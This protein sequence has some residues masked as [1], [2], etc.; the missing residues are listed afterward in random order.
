MVEDGPVLFVGPPY[1]DGVHGPDLCDVRSGSGDGRRPF[2]RARSGGA[3]HYDKTQ[4]DSNR[5]LPVLSLS[6]WRIACRWSNVV[7]RVGW[8]WRFVEC[9]S[10]DPG[11][12]VAVI[13]TCSVVPSER[14]NPGEGHVC[15]SYLILA[16]GRLHIEYAWMTIDSDEL[17]VYIH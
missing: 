6:L 2:S 3:T 14:T 5:D 15:R 10:V 7:G 16:P 1:R 4:I 17:N 13:Y 8:A 11:P 9:V 12:K